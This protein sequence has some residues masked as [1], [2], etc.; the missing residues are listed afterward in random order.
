MG[1]F[2]YWLDLLLLGRMLWGVAKL[3]LLIVLD[4]CVLVAVYVYIL[5]GFL[6]V[7]VCFV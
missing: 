4:M 1:R 3:H 2:G 5:G 6:V 7:L